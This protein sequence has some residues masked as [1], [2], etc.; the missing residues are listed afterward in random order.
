MQL[1][2]DSMPRQMIWTSNGGG[3]C[4]NYEVTGL[5]AAMTELRSGANVTSGCYKA[6][7]HEV[8]FPVV[9]NKVGDPDEFK[10]G[11]MTG[12]S[13]RF[14]VKTLTAIRVGEMNHHFQAELIF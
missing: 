13:R 14:Q 12:R 9:I 10:I 1:G 2:I 3:F 5:D 8:L 4:G 6:Y 7:G 11:G